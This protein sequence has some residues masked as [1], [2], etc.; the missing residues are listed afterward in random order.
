MNKRIELSYLH[1]H[2]HYK[3]LEKLYHLDFLKI[4]NQDYNKIEKLTRSAVKDINEL[5]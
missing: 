3:F 1:T 5:N 2:T 4:K